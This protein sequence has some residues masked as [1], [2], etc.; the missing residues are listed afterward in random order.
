MKN[1]IFTLILFGVFVL[2]VHGE[3]FSS[4]VKLET[5]IENE[6]EI[7]AELKIFANDFKN[8]LAYLER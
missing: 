8:S 3:K 2:S 6:Q 7:V 1:L 4:I 5:L